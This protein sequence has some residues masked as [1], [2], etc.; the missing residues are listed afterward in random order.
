[1]LDLG[2]SINVMP[3]SIYRDYHSARKQKHCYRG[4]FVQVNKL[5]F[6]ADLYVLDM[7]EET[8]K[9]GS[10]LI[11]GRPFLMTAKT[12]ID[13]HAGTLSIELGDTLVQFNIFEAM[14]H[15][16]EDHSLFGINLLDEIVEEYLQLNN[17][18]EDIEK[19]T[20]STDEISCLGKRPTMWNDIADLEFEAELSV[21]LDQVRNQEHSECTK[22]AIVKVAETEKSPIEQLAT[23]FTAEIKSAIEGRLED[24]IEVNSAK[25][26][27]IKADTLAE[28][29]SAN[30]D[31]IQAGVEINVPPGSDSEAAQEANADSDPTR[32]EVT[33]SSRPKQPKAEIMTVHLVPSQDQVGQTDPSTLTEKSPSLPPMELKPLSNH[34]K[35]AY[36]DSEQQLPITIANNLH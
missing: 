19:F 14:K 17:S 22:D 13:V 5:I 15:R 26:S 21:L 6:P 8:S 29:V 12:K 4:C 34:L 10:T 24:E 27:N 36:L 7:E 33:E 31:Q 11:L 18:N 20:G 35:Y 23:I 25:K 30:E 32:T 9:K 2:A 16:T 28:T 3:T 1:M